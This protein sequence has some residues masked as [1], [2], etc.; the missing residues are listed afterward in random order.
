[1]RS[2]DWRYRAQ[3][4]LARSP[5]R[6]RVACVP[7]WYSANSAQTRYYHSIPS[8]NSRPQLQQ[9]QQTITAEDSPEHNECGLFRKV[10]DMVVARVMRAGLVASCHVFAIELKLQ[11]FSKGVLQ[12]SSGHWPPGHHHPI[13]RDAHSAHHR[14]R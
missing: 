13:A 2:K 7:A 5:L 8:N 14:D 11:I 1:M 6:A 12:A 10:T 3:V 9:Q 4:T